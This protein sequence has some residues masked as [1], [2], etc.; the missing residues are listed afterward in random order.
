M[1]YRLLI[2]LHFLLGT[3]AQIAAQNI[4]IDYTNPSGD[5]VLVVCDEAIF[6]FSLTNTGN[7]E[8]TNITFT[9]QFPDGVAYSP[10]TIV[11]A[12]ELNVS[13]PNAPVFS[14][15]D[16]D[17][18]ES[19]NIQLTATASCEL[20]DDINAMQLFS[21]TLTATH[22]NG[23]NTLITTPYS[24]ETALLVMTDFTD[25]VL[26]GIQ[27]DV[28]TRTFT[29]T[30][31]RLGPLTSFTFQDSHEGGIVI[32][33]D[34]GEDISTQTNVFEILLD[35]DDFATIGDGDNFFELDESITITEEVLITSCGS[36]QLSTLST[37]QAFWGCNSEICQSTIPV[38]GYIGFQTVYVVPEL[39]FI[40]I[41]HETPD[42]Y[43]SGEPFQSGMIIENNSPHTA[44]S[45]QL[46]IIQT[47]GFSGIDATSFVVDSNGVTTVLSVQPDTVV[48]FDAVC[49][50]M[51][52]VHKY[53]FLEIPLLEPGH[54]LTIYW[55]VYICAFACVTERNTPWQ[56]YYSYY[57]AC[58]PLPFISGGN[59]VHNTNPGINGSLTSNYMGSLS[60]GQTI[61]F[62]YMLSSESFLNDD[63]S[64]SIILEIP[65]GLS[66]LPDNEVILDGQSPQN[67]D[68]VPSDT[69][70]LVTLQYN[71][72]FTNDS[73]YLSFD[74]DF[75]CDDLCEEVI[76]KDTLIT[77]CENT[78]VTDAPPGLEL[79]VTSWLELEEG[80]VGTCNPTTCSALTW[81]VDCELPLC[82]DSIPGFADY[83]FSARRINYGLPDNDND[84]IADGG[85]NIDLNLIKDDRIMAGDTV[86]VNINSLVVVDEPGF[87]FEAGQIILTITSGALNYDL[88]S[89][90]FDDDGL[91][92]ISQQLVLYDNSSNT[93]YD[94]G[95]NMPLTI[96]TLDDS[97]TFNF[98][99]DISP[100]SL[101][102]GVCNLP[103]DFSYENG[104]S[105]LFEYQ[106]RINF[107]INSTAG[108]STP[109]VVD[110]NIRP[111][112]FLLDSATSPEEDYFNCG[113][114]TTQLLLT[115]YKYNIV[116]GIHAIPVCEPSSFVGGS[117]FSFLLGEENFFPYEFRPLGQLTEWQQEV[118][119]GIEIISSKLTA[120][121]L[122]E[123]ITV[124]NDVPLPF[125]TTN[126]VYDYDLLPFQTPMLDEGFS[127]LV[128]NEFDAD[129]TLSENYPFSIHSQII[130]YPGLILP[131]V[132]DS[133][134]EKSSSLRMLV[135]KLNL[136]ATFFNNISYDDQATW[137]FTIENEQTVVASFSSDVAENVW[138]RPVSL[139]G[140][141]TDFELTDANSGM[142]FPQVNGIF[143]L[144][145]I[146]ALE[147]VSL[148]L[149]GKNSSCEEEPVLVYYGWN[150]DPY[151]N[152]V[153]TPCYQKQAT[154][155][156]LSPPAALEQTVESPI[157]SHFLCDTIPYH[158]ITVFNAELGTAY[159][160]SIETQL[161]PGLY[162]LPGSSEIAYPTGSTFV[163]VNDP[164]D[165]GNG[166]MLWNIS[167]LE[168]SINQNGLPGFLFNPEH[169]VQLRFKLY[170]DCAFI[171]GAYPI[172]FADAEQVCGDPTNALAE[173]GDPIEIDGLPPPYNASISAIADVPNISC[174]DSITLSVNLTADAT[175]VNGDSI[176][177]TLPAGINYS[178]NSIVGNNNVVIQE[179]FIEFNGGLQI[180]KWPL[181]AGVPANQ[182]IAF[183]ISVTG[184]SD[185]ACGSQI[186]LL[187]TVG[188][189][190][191]LCTTDNSLCDILV[192]TGSNLIQLNIDRANY[193][194]SDFEI[195]ITPSGGNDLV[196]YNIT[197][198]NSGFQSEP[199]IYLDFY[200]DT[201]NSGT[202]TAGDVL[203]AT[204]IFF[205]SLP[206]GSNI[207]LSGNFEIAQG[208]SC[209]LIVVIDE[210]KHCACQGDEQLINTTITY[211]VPNAVQLC[212]GESETIGISDVPG[213][214]Y[215]WTPATGLDCATCPTT[216]LELFNNNTTD[217]TLVY[218]LTEDNGT[219]CITAYEFTIN[220]PPQPAILNTGVVVC[221]GDSVLLT[222]T[223]AE[224]YFWEGP[225]I[226]NPSLPEQWVSPQSDAVYSVTLTDS[227]GCSG[228]DSLTVLTSALPI[229]IAGNDTLLC[230]NNTAQLQAFFDESYTYSWEPVAL[231]DDPFS[232][233]PTI[234]NNVA[235]TFSLTVTNSLGCQNFDQIAISFGDAPILTGPDTAAICLG[236]SVSITFGGALH[237]EW[238]PADNLS[239]DTCATVIA[240]PDEDAT[241]YVTG[242]DAIGCANVDSVHVNI[243][244]GTSTAETIDL[245]EG[246]TVEV[247]GETISTAGIYCDT[248]F[249]S[250]TG[251]DSVH[252]V[253]VVMKPIGDSEAEHL[254]CE[255]ASFELNGMIYTEPGMYC[256]DL[257]TVDGC[258]STH[259]V[260]LS[261]QPNPEIEV[262][263]EVTITLGDTVAFDFPDQY[264]YQWIPSEGL[265]CSDC[266]DPVAFPT[267][268]T[269]YTIIV[270]DSLG[271]I[272]E[273]SVTT[274]SV[275]PICESPYI[276][277]PNAFTPNGD[278]E[279][280][281]LRVFGLG[282]ETLHLAIFNRWGQ[283]VFETYDKNEYWDG[284]F[285]GQLLT[286]DVF[287]Y[288]L[289]IECIGGESF[290]EKGNITLL[291]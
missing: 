52:N 201:D 183:D 267:E 94:C 106:F 8:A 38:E 215:Q 198:D 196:N 89:D 46:E 282:I 271:C 40:P 286:P 220:L 288:L 247:H 161:P 191:A 211:I 129:C 50:V 16:L 28:L 127:M 187:Q 238:T 9:P 281:E 197:V 128:Q 206:N 138:L 165:T 48:M 174:Q 62:D 276:F 121:E 6:Q 291:R 143:Q 21:N 181:L 264:N 248:L 182:S 124:F 156:V 56:Y 84:R 283:K 80:C 236:D 136:D 285:N 278:G 7:E 78:C 253:T 76:C 205:N 93:Y 63:D 153:T 144:D 73:I 61:S 42:C 287:G 252:C 24:I 244:G 188:P 17:V 180:L 37:I 152:A 171:A 74:L 1:N 257:Q 130:P 70:T 4:A 75:N 114:Q 10:G 159:N 64:L 72:P 82:L 122:Q 233:N 169:S 228:V 249:N 231:L 157:G 116:S 59:N 194:L 226:S 279:N 255:G 185:L 277:I 36:P 34:I 213:A 284:R 33:T 145:T 20:I 67:I 262:P 26:D 44:T 163:P 115:G 119:D 96:N 232:D 71:T 217:T 167:M 32:T 186:I 221:P 178:S 154:F 148:V 118:P 289:E 229:A 240:Y 110:F 239:C 90:L 193:A 242:S 49:N 25:L 131:A 107:N 266:P 218:T 31:T 86:A 251:C 162:I 113:C 77:S 146:G 256:A 173:A 112:V 54:S 5:D 35:G 51:P 103:N 202:W 91:L 139:S 209:Q 258:D 269:D 79:N 100:I 259:C 43:C 111:E 57:S 68:I 92:P 150:C 227:F 97:G 126:N 2:L 45:I 99:F 15:P 155:T 214:T 141:V 203:V 98:E 216:D 22:D 88:N 41:H 265:S 60:D 23:S 125:T 135:P 280:D 81:A 87:D 65:C 166:T 261:V 200:I 53:A 250:L 168:D 11:N 132:I 190:S 85:G 164:V 134:V 175:I 272:N 147:T 274:R 142:S 243:L 246:E 69:M 204:D 224:S 172:F 290:F 207:T 210:A 189:A 95:L 12:T 184:F 158:T 237:Y 235:T 117:L 222:T 208:L 55:D 39:T 133:T 29:I 108:A 275:P 223:L 140:L 151:L 177:I 58:P 212:S 254:I 13:N 219:G 160:I 137:E 245:C 170:T 47:S 149:T 104:D 3:T 260:F 66:W 263:T 105:I 268:D 109:P 179:P 120:L 83:T 199:P 234:L 30:N 101:A 19:Q 176:F 195:A 14:I 18:S 273:F 27:G 230:E 225:G 123:N 241:Y 270:T 102:G 192:E